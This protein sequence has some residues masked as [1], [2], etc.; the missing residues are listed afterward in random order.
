MKRVPVRERGACDSKG[1]RKTCEVFFSQRRCVDH[2]SVKVR[3]SEVCRILVFHQVV[4]EVGLMEEGRR[5][6][7]CRS[8]INGF[9]GKR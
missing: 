1:F 6:Q 4:L 9:E 8:A 2:R 5:V 7:G 3:S